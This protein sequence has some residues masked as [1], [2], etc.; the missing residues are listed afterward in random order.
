MG[1][2]PKEKLQTESRRAREYGID[3]S[4]LRENLRLSVMERFEQHQSALNTAIALRDAVRQA[5]DR[6]TETR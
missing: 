2:A 5:H 3:L 6:P 4:V 1:N